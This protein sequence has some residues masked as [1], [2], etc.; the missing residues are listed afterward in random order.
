MVDKPMALNV[1]REDTPGPKFSLISFN[2]AGFLLNSLTDS[3]NSDTDDPISPAGAA[4]ER[5][6]LT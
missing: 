5:T 2:F 3:C 6:S 4:V 1:S